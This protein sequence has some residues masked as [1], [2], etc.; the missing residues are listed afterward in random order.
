MTCKS[1]CFLSII[2]EGM[3]ISGK[4]I[5][6]E[7][8]HSFGRRPSFGCRE[9]RIQTNFKLF[10]IGYCALKCYEMCRLK[11]G[12]IKFSRFLIDTFT[13]CITLMN[14]IWLQTKLFRSACMLFKMF[15]MR[16]NF[17]RRLGMKLGRFISCVNRWIFQF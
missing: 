4:S 14:L 9:L 2:S 6:V 13:S 17:C 5:K 16:Q 10:L 12:A 15:R 3:K 8:P 1:S 7:L 11:G